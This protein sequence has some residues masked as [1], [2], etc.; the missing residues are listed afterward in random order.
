MLQHKDYE[1][2]ENKGKKKKTKKEKAKETEPDEKIWTIEHQFKEGRW[3]A[4]FD[5]YKKLIK[6]LNNKGLKFNENPT[7]FYIGL[8]SDKS[9]FCQIH[10]QKSGMKIWL[11]LDIKDISE[12]ASL[13]VRDVSNIGHWG[14]GNIECV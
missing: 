6:E 12:Q 13:N 5:L 4:T 14:M 11:S 10:G 1:E 8:I 7:K 9:N 3:K 2:I